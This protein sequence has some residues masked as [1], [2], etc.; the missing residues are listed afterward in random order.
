MNKSVTP[1][2]QSPRL[3]TI[4]AGGS[5]KAI[6]PQDFESVWRIANAVVKAGMAPRGLETAEK[7]MVAIMHGLEIGL[8][9]MNA[10]QSIAVINGKPTIYGDG[11]I[12]LVRGSGLLEW[13][14]E[15]EETRPGI[16]LIA[17]CRVKR[18]GESQPIERTFSEADA[19]T[20][21]LWNK[22]GRNGEPTPWVTYPKRMLLMRARAFALRDGFADVLKGL[23]IKEEVEDWQ[24]I[25]NGSARDV[26]PKDDGP[27]P[28]PARKAPRAEPTEAELVHELEAGL[29]DGQRIEWSEEVSL[30]DEPQRATADDVFDGAQF[31]KDIEGAFAACEDMASLFEA[32]KTLVV[33]NLPNVFPPDRKRVKALWDEHYKRIEVQE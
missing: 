3:P 10:L 33:P 11:A 5:V 22:R 30:D 13:I 19:K 26:T 15:T 6:V 7:A 2:D 31:L 25:R 14:E 17:V 18:K 12:G 28:P 27:P 21:E 23:G 29:D 9:P 20:A 16:G 24:S 1:I 32:H 8:T 4:Q